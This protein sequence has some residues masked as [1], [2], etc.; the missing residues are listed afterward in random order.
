MPPGQLTQMD[1]ELVID[2]SELA[3]EAPDSRRVKW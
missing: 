3:W 2:V 1:V